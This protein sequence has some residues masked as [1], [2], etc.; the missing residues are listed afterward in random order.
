MPAYTRIENG[1]TIHTSPWSIDVPSIFKGNIADFV[2]QTPGISE[3]SPINKA[4]PNR[5]LYI[6]A[7]DSTKFVT[8]AE[9]RDLIGKIA[10]VLKTQYKIKVGDAV[11]LLL[12]NSI[13]LPALHLGILAAGGVVS[14]A[15]VFYL[16]HE[17]RHQLNVSQAKLVIGLEQFLDT[18]EKATKI[19]DDKKTY[20]HDIITLDNIISKAQAP[21]TKWEPPIKYHGDESKTRHAYYCFSSGTS[22]VPKGVITSHYNIIS[23]VSQQHIAAHEFLYQDGNIYAAVL[24]M[25]HIYGLSTFIYAVPTIGLSTIVVFEKFDFEALLTKITEHM[26][27]FLHVVPPMAVLF[28]KS[29]VLDKYLPEVRKSLKG[30]LS[31]AAPLSQSLIDE[32]TARFANGIDVTQSYGL[33]ETSPINTFGSF[34]RKDGYFNP[35]SSGWLMPGLEARLV[36]ANGEDVHGVG[37]TSRGELWLRGPNV[38]QGYIR[39]K[40]AT[41]SA[42]DP[43][44]VWFKTGD[45]G[46]ASEEG[47]WFIVDRVKELIK[48]KGHQVAPAE[49][50]GIILEHPEVSDAAVTG[51]NL[52]EEGTELPRAYIVLP[53]KITNDNELEKK[54]LEIK[55]WFDQKVARHKQLWGG[56]VVLD[57][58]PKSPSGKIQRRLLRDRKD[59]KVYGY[60]TGAPKKSQA[61][62]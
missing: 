34:N 62:L 22:G 24:P 32:I 46:Y 15:N 31:G 55:L 38:M 43:T 26:I 25:S 49:L 27:S 14:P 45:I 20:V 5:K 42:F 48:S 13:Y 37:E 23:N 8:V 40:E 28:A 4:Q 53:S 30:L 7:K 19:N 61:K 50:E 39:N 1:L 41:E 12:H 59:D 47:L 52:P 17:L 29:P 57:S 44:G 11:C 21:G 3:S 10:H 35:E 9:Q 58:I 36:D 2:L 18:A 51:I 56:I 33:T 16:P 60:K 54:V 6:D